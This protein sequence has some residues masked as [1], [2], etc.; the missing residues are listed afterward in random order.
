L[1]LIDLGEARGDARVLR[2]T[3]AV[4]RDSKQVARA[5][6]RL[7]H[8]LDEPQT[9]NAVLKAI[10]EYIARNEKEVDKEIDSACAKLLVETGHLDTA[11][12]PETLVLS[13]LEEESR[14]DLVITYIKRLL[15]DPKLTTEMRKRLSDGLRSDD[16][17]VAWGCARCLW[18]I[19]S[20][21]D[22]HL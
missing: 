22:P 11:H 14:H 19:G 4:L 9:A 6:P 17:E 18:E 12:L 20:R 7:R 2:I 21:T 15:D 10:S 16:N 8:L 1:M 5:L 13:G 3:R